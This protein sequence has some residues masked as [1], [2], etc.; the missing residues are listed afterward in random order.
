VV[1]KPDPNRIHWAQILTNTKLKNTEVITNNSQILTVTIK[2]K[3]R[4][5]LW[6]NECDIEKDKYVDKNYKFMEQT[7]CDAAKRTLE[8]NRR[9]SKH[10]EI[11]V[12]IKHFEYAKNDLIE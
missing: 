4:S 11:T 8:E 2:I 12:L 5:I 9:Y 1:I 10:Y 6:G 3:V 7:L